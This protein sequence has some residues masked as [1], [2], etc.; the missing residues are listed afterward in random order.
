M[1][2]VD[3]LRGTLDLLVLKALSWGKAHGYAIARW[4][5]QT[6]DDALRIEEGSLYPA[7][8]RLEQRGLVEAD[9]GLSEN[10]RRARYYV[11][12]AEGRR[13]L[14]TESA[15]WDRFSRAV[16]AALQAPAGPALVP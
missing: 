16:F 8:H 11:L 15:S 14:R 4:I 9:W 5:E 12:T 1:A 13:A 6:T 3:V 2:P 10:N 7:L